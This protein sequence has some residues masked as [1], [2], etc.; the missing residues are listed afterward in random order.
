MSRSLLETQD[1]C[2]SPG[3]CEEVNLD[4]SEEKKDEDKEVMVSE[5]KKDEDKEVMASEKKDEDEE[6]MEAKIRSVPRSSWAQ[7][8][9]SKS[10]IV[11][12]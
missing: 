8:F 9:P 3:L 12:H 6:D 4:A 11:H 1:S 10:C 2:L 5:E 7:C